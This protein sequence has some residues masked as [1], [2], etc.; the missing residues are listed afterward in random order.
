VL[1]LKKIELAVAVGV[2]VQASPPVAL[3]A[4]RNEPRPP[5]APGKLIEYGA[6]TVDAVSVT[7][8]VPAVA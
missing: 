5:T 2:F 3:L 8:S 1:L 6:V 7:A 4:N